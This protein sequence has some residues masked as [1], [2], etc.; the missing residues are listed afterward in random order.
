MPQSAGGFLA[1]LIEITIF[2]IKNDRSVITRLIY[3]T[4]FFLVH[5]NTIILLTVHCTCIIIIIQYILQNYLLLAVVVVLVLI[6]LKS[7]VP[8]AISYQ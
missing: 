6:H 5:K 3:G 1:S 7:F 8:Y 4:S 2:A